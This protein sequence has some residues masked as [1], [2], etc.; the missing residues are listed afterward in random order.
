MDRDSQATPDLLRIIRRRWPTIAVAVLLAALA[1]FAVSQVQQKSYEA[2]ASLVFGDRSAALDLLGQ[3]SN[4]SGNDAERVAATMVELVSARDVVNRTAREVNRAPDKV[5]EAVQVE[6]K[7]VSNVVN[8]TA[9]DASPRL[10]AELANTY[11]A[12][13]IELRQQPDPADLSAAPK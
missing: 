13:Y 10:C 12:Q 8:V 1:A 7:G 6:G 3:G 4:S 2:T 11:A 9:S 5:D